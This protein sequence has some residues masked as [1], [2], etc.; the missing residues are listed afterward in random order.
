VSEDGEKDKE[1]ADKRPSRPVTAAARRERRAS[2]S[3]AGKRTGADSE[4][5]SGEGTVATNRPTPKGKTSDRPAKPAG[6]GRPTPK[7]GSKDAKQAS[8]FARIGRFIR[9]VWAELRKVIWPTRKQMATYTTVVLVFLVFMVALVAGL[10]YV[11]FKGMDVVF[12]K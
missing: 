8:V 12:G 11:F 4:A 1:R 7:R 6:K 5:D 2:A 3:P 9:E 10:D